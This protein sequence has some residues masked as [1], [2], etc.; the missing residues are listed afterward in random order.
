MT[1]ENKQS[2]L[3]NPVG[4]DAAPL[5]V[6]CL[7]RPVL[8]P[9]SERRIDAIYSRLQT[10]EERVF[11]DN[12]TVSEWPP[13]RPAPVE[14]DAD[15]KFREAQVNE[16]EQWADRAD[17]SVSPP[18]DRRET[19]SVASD[20]SVERLVTPTIC[21]ACYHD[22]QLVGV[23][24]HTDGET[25]HTVSEAIAALRTGELPEPLRDAPALATPHSGDSTVT[26]TADSGPNRDAI[27]EFSSPSCS[28]CG[29]TLLNVQGI[30]DCPGCAGY[31]DDAKTPLA[32]QR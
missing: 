4:A 22:D 26:G 7:V 13:H 25:T 21:L 15:R 10:L 23:F 5:E 29:T 32:Q 14:E 30:L 20:Q 19:T 8:S 6:E 1:D 18:F 31:R 9:V 12:V 24:P 28:D 27:A 3:A 11:V 16:F 2:P 17:V